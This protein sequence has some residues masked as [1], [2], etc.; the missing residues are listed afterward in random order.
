[1]DKNFSYGSSNNEKLI[2][3]KEGKYESASNKS[4]S[5]LF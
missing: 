2:I 1:M 3:F 5:K 4:L